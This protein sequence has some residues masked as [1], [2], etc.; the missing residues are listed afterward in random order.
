[1]SSYLGN[2]PAEKY[3][4]LLQQ[5]FTSP[6]GTIFTLTNSVTTSV[7]LAL[8]VNNTR[9]D[10]S[11]Y[12]AAGTQLTLTEALVSGDEMYCLYYGRTTETVATPDNS[13]GTTKLTNDA[14]DGTKIADNAVGNEH[15]EDDAVGIAELSATGSP[16]ATTFLRGDNTWAA[17]GGGAWTVVNSALANNSSTI[18]LTGFS[19]TYDTYVIILSA[20]RADSTGNQAALF[21]QIGDGSGFR[22]HNEYQFNLEHHSYQ[23]GTNGTGIT[24]VNNGGTS[25]WRIFD[26]AGL[27]SGTRYGSNSTFYLYSPRQDTSPT[28]LTCPQIWGGSI[29]HQ[30]NNHPFRETF[31]GIYN[32]NISMTQIKL[33]PTSGTFST[34]RF[35]LYGIKHA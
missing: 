24:T 28:S 5:T 18:T 35:T 4:T 25:S 14:I 7:D 1:M 31:A 3:S 12:T 27:S 29:T 32:Q 22:T 23:S 15:L 6:T 10:P 17:A 13:I 26:G 11:T 16:D 30:Y 34:G 33:Y 2:I 9:Q 19:S 8:F 20:V 21:M